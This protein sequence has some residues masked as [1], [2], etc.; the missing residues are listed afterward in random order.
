MEA[1]CSSAVFDRIEIE[2][3]DTYVVNQLWGCRLNDSE[4]KDCPNRLLH[5]FKTRIPQ[6][7]DA[8]SYI[9]DAAKKLSKQL[10][11]IAE[12]GKD[13]R[14]DPHSATWA[15]ASLPL[16]T[17][18]KIASGDKETLEHIAKHCPLPIQEWDGYFLRARSSYYQM[19]VRMLV[20][21]KG[22]ESY[23]DLAKKRAMKKSWDLF[24][25]LKE[26]SFP[27]Y[28]SLSPLLKYDTRLCALFEIRGDQPTH[29]T[30]Q[31]TMSV[32][33]KAFA[34]PSSIMLLQDL[35]LKTQDR[36]V[37]HVLQGFSSCKD[38]I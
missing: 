6:R 18:R 21:A 34:H 4:Y 22:I 10:I 16:L 7:Q 36:Y 27:S 33:A 32:L 15:L 8:C 20:T 30:I 5:I 11:L 9:Q 31:S 19:D 25:H 37:F 14:I 17:L 38:N 29:Q 12:K 2:E 24:V 1:K 23:G 28:E 13:K 26:D 35:S 3:M